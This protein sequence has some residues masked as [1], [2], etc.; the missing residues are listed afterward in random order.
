[1]LRRE[2]FLID[3]LAQLSSESRGTVMHFVSLTGVFT[4]LRLITRQICVP[5]HLGASALVD[6]L[7]SSLLLVLFVRNQRARSAAS[8]KSGVQ[9]L[10]AS[11]LAV[12][13]TSG[14]LV[15]SLQVITLALWILYVFLSLDLNCFNALPQ[16]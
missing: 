3:S 10:L 9:K 8:R 11:S 13:I 1:M 15:T 14:A 12:F 16:S 5:L 6:L 4:Q 2:M 7:L